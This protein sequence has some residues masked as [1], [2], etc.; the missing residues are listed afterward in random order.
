MSRKFKPRQRLSGVRDARLIVIASEGANTEPQ[1]FRGLAA[2]YQNSKVKIHL[3]E[4]ENPGESSPKHVLETLD[5]FQGKY[6]WENG[7]EFWLVIDVDRW[8]DAKLAEI[9]QVSVQKDYNLAVSNPC[10]E[11]WL[12]LHLK[13]LDDYTSETLTEFKVNARINANRNRLEAEL[14]EI[15]GEYNKKNLNPG[16]FLPHIEV[17]VERARK[18]DNPELRWP[19]DLGSRVFIG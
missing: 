7:D 1:Y 4:R 2:K 18:L 8:G 3:L 14:L 17:A 5:D 19:N 12:L 10:F 6:D 11:L 16:R 15:L 9:A 13:S